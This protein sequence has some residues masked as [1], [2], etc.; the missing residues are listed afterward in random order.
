MIDPFTE[1]ADRWNRATIGRKHRNRK[2]ENEWIYLETIKFRG[3]QFLGGSKKPK[4]SNIWLYSE[5]SNIIKAADEKM[6]TIGGDR[7]LFGRLLL[8]AK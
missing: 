3:S 2:H 4:N 8:A 6:T 1:E 5:E 7:D